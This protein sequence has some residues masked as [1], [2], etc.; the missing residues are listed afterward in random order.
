MLEP[1][2]EGLDGG[3]DH[4]AG[5]DEEHEDGRDTK[6]SRKALEVCRHADVVH[7][8]FDLAAEDHRDVTDVE[9]D[10]EQH[11]EDIDPAVERD[12]ERPERREQEE[13]DLEAD[14]PVQDYDVREEAR[15]FLDRGIDRRPPAKDRKEGD[16]GPAD[17]DEDP[18]RA[19]H[20]G[21]GQ[22]AC[23]DPAFGAREHA[24][25]PGVER[26]DGVF[27]R[28]GQHGEHR[29]RERLGDVLLGGLGGPREEE[30]GPE[31]GESGQDHCPERR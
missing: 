28:D 2:G 20:V 22:V 17:A 6:R 4:C 1:V 5:V 12:E 23:L 24:R 18:V 13:D 19:G 29:D 15:S 16:A 10:Q 26:V 11:V 30:R 8:R 25:V 9:P 27:W 14:L 3:E 31:N 21:D 7:V